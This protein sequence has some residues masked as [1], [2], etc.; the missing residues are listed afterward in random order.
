MGL[1][2]FYSDY[3]E[4]WAEIKN[5]VSLQGLYDEL[6]EFGVDIRDVMIAKALSAWTPFVGCIGKLLFYHFTL[7]MGKKLGQMIRVNTYQSM[8]RKLSGRYEDHVIINNYPITEYL[9]RDLESYSLDILFHASLGVEPLRQ[10]RLIKRIIESGKPQ[11][12]FLNGRYEG[13]YTLRSVTAN[14]Q[15][16]SVV[17]GKSL[18]SGGGRPSIITATIELKQ[19]ITPSEIKQY[20]EEK[21]AEEE[22]EESP[23]DDRPTEEATQDDIDSANEPDDMVDVGESGDVG[24]GEPEVE[25]GDGE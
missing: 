10:Y 25:V 1:D 2:K 18:M 8:E 14:E 3:K 13:L 11:I 17:T 4:L 5:T 21:A 24:V 23:S 22:A 20:A 6:I 12:V 15:A 16:W 7:D 9:G 19:Y